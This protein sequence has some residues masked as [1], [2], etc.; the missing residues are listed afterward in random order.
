MATHASAEKRYRQSV[1]RRARNRFAKATFRTAVKNALTLAQSGD[2][3][4]AKVAARAA[5]RLLD[6]AAVHG[7]IHKKTAQRQISRLDIRIAQLAAAK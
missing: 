3:A 6:K 2:S 4:G 7:V 1:K 5:T